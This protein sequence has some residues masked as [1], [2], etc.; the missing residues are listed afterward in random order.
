MHKPVDENELLMMK[1]ESTH[2]TFLSR[3]HVIHAV[4]VETR[5]YTPG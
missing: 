1:T 4:Y 5:V 3:K 2:E